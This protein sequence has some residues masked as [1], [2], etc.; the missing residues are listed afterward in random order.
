M[1]D[2]HYRVL[3]DA[4]VAYTYVSGREDLFAEPVNQIM[5]LCASGK[6]DG[7]LAFHSVSII[8]Y[9]LR[10]AREDQRR[11]MM[12]ELCELLTVKG[13]SHDEIIQAIQ[14]EE[15][16]DFEDCLQD[17]CAKEAGCD[18]IVTVN[19]KDFA[20]SE[21]PAITPDQMM[22]RMNAKAMT[23]NETQIQKASSEVA[24]AEKKQIFIG[25][26]SNSHGADHEQDGAKQV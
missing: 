7:F 4:N 13:A 1:N 22:E 10:K 8:W 24:P 5:K 16:K 17:K 3:V 15:F 20:H 26:I 9:L 14:K 25:Q 23:A 18:F 12:M 2:K 19:V 11:R 6:I 21:V